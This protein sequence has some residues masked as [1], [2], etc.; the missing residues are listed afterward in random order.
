M[1][2]GFDYTLAEAV[3]D[4]EIIEFVIGAFEKEGDVKFSRIHLQEAGYAGCIESGKQQQHVPWAQNIFAVNSP[5][6][7]AV[8]NA[9]KEMGRFFRRK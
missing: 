9:D 7:K 6:G 8:V 5:Y 1:N 4:K 2:E 3:R